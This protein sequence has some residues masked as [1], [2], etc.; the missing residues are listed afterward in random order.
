[1]VIAR[2]GSR[3]LAGVTVGAGTL[4]LAGCVAALPSPPPDVGADYPESGIP[5]E[6]A[7]PSDWLEGI[8]GESNSPAGPIVGLRL[9]YI[10]DQWMWRVRSPDPGRDIWGESVT[11]PDRGQEALYDASTL[12][13]VREQHVTLTDRELAELSISAY[14]AAQLSGEVYPSPRLI[15]LERVEKDGRPAWRITTYDT[16]TGAQS[17]VTL[18]AEDV[19]EEQW[20]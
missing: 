20:G 15:E 14:D 16:E 10:E 2:R 11:E 4:C 17:V 5:T 13:R 19:S 18:G 9:E 8:A 12:A 7:W 3:L 1:M 6:V